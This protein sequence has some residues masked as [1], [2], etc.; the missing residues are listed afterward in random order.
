MPD[1]ER[2]PRPPTPLGPA[3]ESLRNN[4]KRIREEKRLTFVELSKQLDEIGRPIPVL[5]LRRIEKGERRVDVDDL[6]ALADV[7]KT[8]PVLLLLPLGHQEQVE[9]LPGREMPAWEAVKWFTGRDRPLMT[10]WRE[11]DV[12][13]QLWEEH[14]GFV[15]DWMVAPEAMF[16]SQAYG[17]TPE[18]AE[19]NLRTSRRLSENSL[20]VTRARMSALGLTPPALPEELRHIDQPE[21]GE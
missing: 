12:P 14:E 16:K 19:K 5:G 7:L 10:D 8:P 6:M 21:Q 17:A 2:T 20:R 13:T 1:K 11:S 9:V 4:I 15:N 3:G 18:V